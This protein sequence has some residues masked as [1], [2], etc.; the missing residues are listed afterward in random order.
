MSR[1]PSRKLQNPGTRL[2][3]AVGRFFCPHENL[4][5]PPARNLDLEVFSALAEF[6]NPTRSEFGTWKITKPRLPG[7]WTWKIFPPSQKLQTRP[8]WKTFSHLRKSQNPTR[9]EFGTPEIF[10]PFRK[11][12]TPP[13]RNLGLGRFFS[14]S[15]KFYKTPL[16]R[17]LALGRFFCPGRN[18][19]KTPPS[20]PKFGTREIFLP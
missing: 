11:S 14:P 7:I 9:G 3:F 15:W 20:C 4:Q 10:P 19:Y 17:N 2:E 1:L 12:Q 5:T 13:A 8:T 16:A 18:F 6:T